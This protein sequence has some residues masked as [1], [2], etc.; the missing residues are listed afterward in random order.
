[1][2]PRLEVLGRPFRAIL[3]ALAAALLLA[4]AWQWL[5]WPDVAA[6]GTEP[7]QSTAF[8]RAWEAG[9]RKAG[10]EVRA[11]HRWVPY[12]EISDRLKRAVLVAEDIDFFSHH[13]FAVDEMKTALRD[14]V[15]EGKPLR[16]ATSASPPAG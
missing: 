8:I 2:T 1:M 9:Q 16:G 11:E 13:G 14:T 7:P 15:R 3:G 6:L 4:A 5:T 10:R 12:R